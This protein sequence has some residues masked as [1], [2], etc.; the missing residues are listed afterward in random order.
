MEEKAVLFWKE[1]QN[2]KDS[3]MD[4]DSLED[5]KAEELLTFLDEILKKYSEGVDFI[6]G[7][8]T[9]EGRKITF[10]AYSD[11][12]YFEDVI[13][14]V[15]N[16]PLMDFWQIEAFL[17]PEGKGVKIEYEGIKL[18]SKDLFF[19]PLESEVVKNKIGLR[20][21][22]EKI[23]QNE[24]YISACYLLCEKMI[25]EYYATMLIDYFDVDNL[26]KDYKE[27]GYLPLDYLPDFI[28][29]KKS[30]DNKSEK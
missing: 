11:K 19:L 10:T 24:D 8:L 5:S 25:G 13:S 22:G 2:I 4:I 17:Q 30:K 9:E 29:W 28:E 27:E 20:I 23:E 14:L 26:P 21:A 15:E 16:V 12:D 3:L 1:F 18:D 6:L 7:D